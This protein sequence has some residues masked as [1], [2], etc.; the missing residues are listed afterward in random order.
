MTDLV[1]TLRFYASGQWA[2]GAPGFVCTEA[3]EAITALQ[4]Q[5]SEARAAALEDAAKICDE[6]QASMKYEGPDFGAAISA[7]KIRAH[8]TKEQTGAG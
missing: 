6:V 2:N 3:A 5:L 4:S 8:L 7:E 1:E